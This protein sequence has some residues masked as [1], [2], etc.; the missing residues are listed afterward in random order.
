MRRSIRRLNPGALIVK[1]I[2]L[3]AIAA[4]AIIGLAG[5]LLPII[6]GL[7]FLALAAILLRQ[8]QRRQFRL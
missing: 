5:L 2:L 3:V 7:L 8:F 6:P 4:C 1:S